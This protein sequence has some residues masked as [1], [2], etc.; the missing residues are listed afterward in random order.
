SHVLAE[1]LLMHGTDAVVASAESVRSFYVKQVHADPARVRVI[2]NAVDWSALDTTL[3]PGQLRAQLGIAPDALVVSIIARLTEQKA[4]RVLFDALAAAPALATAHL[5]VVG[6]GELR[7][8]LEAHVRARGLSERVHFLGARR[9]LGD[10]LAA[11][12]VFAMPSFWEG[13]PLSLVLAMGAGLP[14]VATRV[15]GMP[16][17]VEHGKTGLLVA[18]GSVDEL[19]GALSALAEDPSLR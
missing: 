1:R 19:A 17:V 18:P 12:D 3:P 16:E 7:G 6:D 11:S 5:L 13:L 15:A 4:H 2:Y 8:S 9:D 10:L 14:V